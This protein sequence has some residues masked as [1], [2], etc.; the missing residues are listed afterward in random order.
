MGRLHRILAQGCSLIAGVIPIEASAADELIMDFRAGSPQS[1][2]SSGYSAY[3]GAWEDRLYSPTLAVDADGVPYHRP[4]VQFDGTDSYLT[5]HD[6]APVD[7]DDGLSVEAWFRARELTEK[8][9]I[10]SNTEYSGY[11]LRLEGD[12]LVGL[13]NVDGQYL[14][15]VS[16]ATLDAG[17]DYGATFVVQLLGEGFEGA[18]LSSGAPR[19]RLILLLDGQFD[20]WREFSI[21]PDS[22]I[23]NS[24]VRPLIGAEPDGAGRAHRWYFSGLI[25]S[26]TVRNYP[27][28]I[29]ERATVREALFSVG[30][31]QDGSVRGGRAAYLRGIGDSSDDGGKYVALDSLLTSAP[32]TEVH[33]EGI[34]PF[35]ND[36]YIVQGVAHSCEGGQRCSDE[37]LYLSF[38]HRGDGGEVD[39]NHSLIAE[40]DPQRG[41]KVNRCFRVGGRLSHSHVGG[42][43]QY[44]GNIYLSSSE[45]EHLVARFALP[46]RPLTDG[47]LGE[48]QLVHPDDEWQ[49]EASSFVSF[50][51][52]PS[53]EPGLLVGKYC[54]SET[55]CESP[56]RAYLYSLD[57]FG[58]VLN[59][60][61]GFSF[62]LPVGA[63]GVELTARSG[64][65]EIVVA[66]SV[67]ISGYP[68]VRVN[69]SV[70]DCA[71]PLDVSPSWTIETPT[72]GEDTVLLADRIWTASESGSRWFNLRDESPWIQRGDFFPFIYSV[73][74][75]N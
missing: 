32:S 58:G 44:N 74:P 13:V 34:V 21:L 64:A 46:H 73:G 68:V 63:Q 30:A 45:E 33:V 27:L 4:V 7:T 12:R 5:M 35:V 25:G 65:Y 59:A 66:K 40:L 2:W 51:R 49:V 17:R 18:N 1:P 48:C 62:A 47:N 14:E 29:G 39:L 20:A 52:V 15:V 72:G 6:F 61:P 41:M 11:T 28:D 38:Y 56:P 23:L 24:P 10:F 3:F 55:S 67:S 16:N 69:C 19:A 50:A 31:S 8:Q 57:A 9:V 54:Q 22:R 60:S 43:A 36:G 71:A 53:G 26:V 70:R 75:W 37:R 42:L